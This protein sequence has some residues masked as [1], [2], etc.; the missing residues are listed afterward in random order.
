MNDAQNFSN[1]TRWL[2]PFHFFVAPLMLVNLIFSAV[3]LFQ[4]PS[5]DRG[6]FVLLAIGLVRL[7]L[8]SRTQ[9]LAAQ[10]RLIRLEEKLR[11][12]SVLSAEL[13]ESA[14]K[15]TI[16]QMIGLRFA[17]DAELPELIE[18]TLSGQLKDQKAIKLAVKQW[19]AD[20]LRV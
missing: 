12:Q 3:R 9:A 1:H 8:L 11:Y 19:R 20:L 2:P 17:S 10:D 13:A 15:L 16:A 6:M 14:N 18:K 5:V 4:D 7:T